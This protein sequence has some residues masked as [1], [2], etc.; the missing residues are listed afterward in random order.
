MN[1]F[2]ERLKPKKIVIKGNKFPKMY[3]MY[4]KKGENIGEI[5]HNYEKMQKKW[6]KGICIF[7]ETEQGKIL[8]E[9]RGNTKLNP[10]E[11]DY[12]SGH[13]ED[14][15]TYMQAAYREAREELGLQEN[16]IEKLTL[17]QKEVPLIFAGR[18]FLIQ[19]LYGK[20]NTKNIKIDNVE[21]EKYYQ[22][23]PEEAFKKLREGKTKFP[24]K[25][26]EEA[27]EQIIEHV[28]EKINE[29]KNIE[30]QEIGS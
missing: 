23:E 9:R 2:K 10:Y 16:Q 27:L 26:N 22:E 24:Y 17:I 3:K 6:L 4:N 19:F 25:G 21:V 29:F 1:E 15:E 7:L 28:I 30:E 8:M 11:D 5:N 12:C 14:D 20:I 13:V 18:K